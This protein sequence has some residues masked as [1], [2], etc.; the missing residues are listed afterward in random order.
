VADRVHQLLATDVALDKL[1]ARQIAAVDAE[2]LLRNPHVIVRNP[3]SPAN[4]G[5]RRLLIG[6][7]DGGRALTLVI[8]RTADPESW[9]DRDGLEL[10]RIRAYD[11]REMSSDPWTSA[12]PQ[13]G[14]FDGDLAEL[15]PRYIERREGDPDG[16]LMILVSV[17]G[18][19]AERLQ[20]LSE[21]RGKTSAD[22][23]ADL[24]RDADRSVA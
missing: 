13:P 8:E 18:E 9:V 7:T 22:V 2:Q 6:R 11:V 19:D 4:P 21:R 12:D 17:E 23:V 20:R 3:R 1:G 24:L 15:D 5:K 10:D 16:K 14:A